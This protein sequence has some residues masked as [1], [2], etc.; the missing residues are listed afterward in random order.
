[1]SQFGVMFFDDPVA[2]FSNIHAHLRP[3]GRLVFVCWQGPD[4]N[5]WFPA[6]VL[7]PY[8]PSPRLSANGGPPVGPFA[9]ANDSYVADVLTRARFSE[10]RQLELSVDVALPGD[11]FFDRETVDAMRIAPDQADRAWRDLQEFGETLRGSDGLFHVT[12]A[13][14]IVDARTAKMT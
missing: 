10:V 6:A 7:A 1:M 11:A 12:L 14:K 9:F 3:G 13:P 4:R 8:R 5:R 2:A